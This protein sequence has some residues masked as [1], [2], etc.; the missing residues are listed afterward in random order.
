MS[1]ETILVA[2][3]DRAIRVV[4]DQA[5][6]RL[7]YNVRSTDKA[8]TLWQWIGEGGGRSRHH[9]C[10]DARWQR[11]RSHP[12]HPPAPSRPAHHRHERA[13]HAADGSSCRRA[14]CLRLCGKALRPEPID[15]AGRTRPQ[16]GRAGGERDRAGGRELAPHRP[17]ARHAGD[18]SRHGAVD[19]NRS[20]GDDLRRIRHRQGACRPRAARLRQAPSWSVRGHQHGG[21]SARA[22]RERIVRP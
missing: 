17:L 1:G 9:R 16:P 11:A 7:G 15:G 13:E 22:G 18:L 8:A 2:D 14:R 10:A 19:G 12:R 3:D 6:G 20:D 21:H 5:L 4:L